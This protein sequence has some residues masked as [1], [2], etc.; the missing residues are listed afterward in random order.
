VLLSAE[1]TPDEAWNLTKQPRIALSPGRFFKER[2]KNVDKISRIDIGHTN[3]GFFVTFWRDNK[4]HGFKDV[5]PD[6]IT[7]LKKRMGFDWFCDFTF[8]TDTGLVTN[9]IRRGGRIR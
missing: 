8:H 3:V 2:N 7:R 4:S 5:K 1:S 6:Q 9:Y